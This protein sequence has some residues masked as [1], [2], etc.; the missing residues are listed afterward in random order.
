MNREPVSRELFD[1]VMVPNYAPGSV[2][3]V[4][5]EGSH[6]WDQEG[7][8]YIDL[9]GGIAVTCL[10]HNHP[11]LVGALMEQAEKIWH[12]SNVMTNEPALRL[13]KT[14][15]DLTFA[16]RVFFANSGGEANE[17]A[18]KL[19]RRYAW[20]HFGPE[21]NEII[22]F[23]SSFHGRTLFT[24]SVGGQPKY[25]EGF[26]PAPGGIHHADFNDLESVRKLISKDKTCA[27]VVEPIQGEGGVMPGDPE[28][29]KG[30]RQLCD[31]NDALLVFD[32]V[33]SGVGRTGHLYAYQMYGVTPDILSTAKGLG[34]GFPVAA[35]L[36]TEKVAK[37]LGIGTLGSTYGG[38][39]LA[40][41]VAQRVIDT[42]S[43]PDI[44]KGV[45]AR[46]ERLR[47]RMMDIGERYG[48]FSEVRGSG[49]LLGCVL[50]E[51]WKGKAK[52]FLNAG[53]NEGVMVLIAGPN[54]VRLAPSLIIPEPDIDEALAR[55]EAGVKKVCGK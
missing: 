8:E 52:E 7:K 28:F 18:F 21:K 17:A 10:G 4:K 26:E 19:A 23:K 13:A 46:S 29:L 9:A 40:C 31:E 55:F 50:T 5:G 14:L 3:P 37:S 42:V 38:N 34:G 22:S 30:L 43:Q 20:E 6:V 44:L 15:C 54:V 51:E 12:L 1:E 33:Q 49:L 32:E 27:V 41:A 16:E 39:A 48:I 36:T 45:G 2:I 11:G 25:L 47:K 24:V 53:L 35:M